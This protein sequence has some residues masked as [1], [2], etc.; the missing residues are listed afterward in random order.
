M[1]RLLEMLSGL[2]LLVDGKDGYLGAGE[3][4]KKDRGT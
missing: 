3:L 2:L 4:A 1:H